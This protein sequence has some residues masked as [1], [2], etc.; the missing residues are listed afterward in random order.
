M[1]Q[2]GVTLHTISLQKQ[3]VGSS[4]FYGQINKTRHNFRMHMVFIFFSVGVYKQIANE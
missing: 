1:H 4:A 2:W 3:K